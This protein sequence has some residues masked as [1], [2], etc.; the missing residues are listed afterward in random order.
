MCALITW[1]AAG[2][3]MKPFAVI[4]VGFVVGKIEVIDIFWLKRK[5]RDFHIF[6]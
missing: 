2:I 6:L 5:E 3:A 4:A 1:S